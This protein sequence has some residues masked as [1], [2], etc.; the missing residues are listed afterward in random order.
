MSATSRSLASSVARARCSAELTDATLVSSSSAT[1]VA[2]QRSTS[3]RISTAR[4][5][6]GRFWSAATKASLIVSRDSTTDAGSAPSSSTSESGIGSS[7]GTS[8]V[9]RFSTTGSRDGPR[10]IGRVRR[11]LPLSMS[12]QTF[13]AIR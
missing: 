10:S 4:W 1:S 12:K 8:G 7:H 6:G 2:F 11:S 3:Q 9:A 5:R 13:V